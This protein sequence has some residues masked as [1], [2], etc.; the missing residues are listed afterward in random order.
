MEFDWADET[1]HAEYGR[2]WL[3]RLL[4][5]RGEDPE[6]WAQVLTRCEELVRARVAETTAEELERIR[7][8]ADRLLATAEGL[9]TRP[10]KPS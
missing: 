5:T 7:A 3:K 2:H 1:L 10:E 9:T 4:E 6:G 8:C